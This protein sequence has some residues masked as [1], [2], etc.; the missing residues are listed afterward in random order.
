VKR[1]LLAVL[2]GLA[3]ALGGTVAWLAWRDPLSALPRAEGPVEV[4]AGPAQREAGRLL[5]H[6]VLRSPDLGSIGLT[7]SLPNPLAERPLPVLVVLGGANTGRKNLRQVPA[8][9]ANIL[10]GYDWPLPRKVP[11]GMDLVGALHD[12]YPQL[13]AVPGQVAAVIGWTADQP[14]ADAERI[15]LLGFSLGALVAPAAQ[16]V[17]Q[18]SGHDIGWTVL[19]YGGAGLGTIL[20]AHPKANLGWTGPWVGAAADLLL[21]P[22]EPAE[23]L[24]QLAGRF[25]LI[26]A[27]EDRLVPRPSFELLR[28]LTPEPKTFVLLDGGHIGTRARQR[29][30]LEEIVRLTRGWLIDQGAVTSP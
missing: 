15:S 21:R 24:P 19:A 1:I 12:L 29:E 11:R 16:R 28:D 14:W 13:L 5:Q 10:V 27:A 7:V 18:S 26:G 3:L 30:L 25:L 2:F 4:V 17:T 23:H 6:Y 8:A 22:I 20:A 9:G